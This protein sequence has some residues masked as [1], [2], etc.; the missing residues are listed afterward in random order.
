[1]ILLEYFVANLIRGHIIAQ[2]SILYEIID[3]NSTPFMNKISER[4]YYI[5]KLYIV[6]PRHPIRKAMGR[7]K[8]YTK[9][10]MQNGIQDRK[11]VV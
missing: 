11:S 7:Q 10:F 6:I 1:M 5:T 9:V 4:C 2:F 8:I 3:D